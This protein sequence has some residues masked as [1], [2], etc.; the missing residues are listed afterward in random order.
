MASV[1]MSEVPWVSRIQAPLDVRLVCQRG[2]DDCVVACIATVAG[3]PYEQAKDAC[4]DAAE[5]LGVGPDDWLPVSWEVMAEAL[6]KLG[7]LTTRPIWGPTHIGAMSVNIVSVPS[8][9]HLGLMHAIVVIGGEPEKGVEGSL[10]LD[11]QNFRPG[12]RYYSRTDTDEGLG[13]YKLESWGDVWQ[14]WRLHP[15]H[16]ALR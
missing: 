12:K 10:V 1:E 16:L 8:L 2:D 11:P 4:I 9:N 15:C 13:R 3:C 7:C 5:V 14:V 6:G